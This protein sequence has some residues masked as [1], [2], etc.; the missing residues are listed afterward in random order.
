MTAT[1]HP[2]T[3]TQDAAD[4]LEERAAADAY[5][6]AINAPPS[7]AVCAAIRDRLAS[8]TVPRRAVR[9]EAARWDEEPTGPACGAMGIILQAQEAFCVRPPHRSGDH[10]D[11]SGNIWPTFDEEY[12]DMLT[13]TTADLRALLDGPSEKPVLYVAR[14]EETG[15]A[16]SLE[17]WAEALVDHADIVA[18]RHELEDAL[19]GPDHPDGVTEDALENL[20]E[21]Y[22]NIIGT[23]TDDETPDYEC[24]D[25]SGDIHPEHDYPAEGQGYECRRCGAECPA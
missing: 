10:E 16:V 17:V 11:Y 18:H 6:R 7:A 15:E 23:I 19:G 13:I 20:L 2:A 24:V 5:R 3:S 9:R 8:G 22:Q 12:E 21:G 1:P 25:G 4:A 14:D